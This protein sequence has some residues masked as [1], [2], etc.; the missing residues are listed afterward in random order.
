M[1]EPRIW[2]V[3]LIAK[4]RGEKKERR[5]TKYVRA[6]TQEGAVRTAKAHSMLPLNASAYA[7]HATP[8]DLGCVPCP[9]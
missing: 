6:T 2:V 9:Q 4:K 1:D 3:T 7:R 8:Q 5:D